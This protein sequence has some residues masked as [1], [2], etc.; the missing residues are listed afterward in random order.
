MGLEHWLNVL[1]SPTIPYGG[2]DSRM[3][4]IVRVKEIKGHCPVYKVGELLDEPS[5]S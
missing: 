5:S 4:L 3:D 2:N 1:G